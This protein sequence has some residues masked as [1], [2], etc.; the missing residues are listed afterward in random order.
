MK[1]AVYAVKGMSCA[2]C[3]VRIEKVVGRLDGVDNASVNLAAEKLALS[4]N[5]QRLNEATLTETVKNIG[6]ELVTEKPAAIETGGLRRESFGIAGMTCA[7]CSTRIEKALHAL[8]G[9]TEASVN[10]AAERAQVVFRPETVRLFEIKAAVTK[11]GYT[12]LEE[13]AASGDEHQQRKDREIRSLK[14]SFLISL[15]FTIPLFYLAM[16]PMLSFVRLPF[17]PFLYPMAQPLAY[18]LT[19]FALT[20]PA[21]IAGRRFYT[22]GFKALVQL[23][24]NMDT[25]IAVGTSAAL[26]YSLYSTLRIILGDARGVEQLY[27]ESAGVIIT[28][29]LLGKTLEA[30]SKGRAGQAIKKLMRLA[31]ATT[32][33]VRDGAEVTVPVRDLEPGDL[34]RVH[35]GERVP[36][37]GAVTEGYSAVDESML[38]GEPI[39]V[40]KMT[41]SP[42]YGGSLNKN[43]TILFRAEK[44]GRETALARII[45]LVEDAQGKKAPIARLA[46]VVSGWFVPLVIGVAGLSLVLWLLAGREFVFAFT[47]FTAVLVIACPCALGLA[48]PAA[49]MTGTGRGAELGILFKSGPALETA[50]RVTTVVLDKTGTLTVGRPRVTAVDAAPGWTEDDV[51]FLAASAERHS[52]HPLAEA[53]LAEAAR[54]GLTPEEPNEFTAVPG[55]GLRARVGSRVLVLGNEKLMGT[56][57]VEYSVLHDE[58]GRLSS[59]GNTVLYLAAD[60]RIAGIVGCADTLKPGAAAAVAELNQLGLECIM[61]TGDSRMAAVAVAAQAGITA[62]EAEVLPADKAAVVQQF[63]AEGKKVIMAGDGINDAPALAQADVGV[64]VGSGTDVAIEAADIVLTRNELSDIPAAVRLARKTMRVIKQNLF[65]AFCYNV[66]GIPVAA[67]LLTLFGGPQLNPMFAAAAMSM[68]SV[69]VVTNALRLKRFKR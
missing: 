37:D 58:A 11:L 42:V 25:L 16:A 9:V 31:P 3:A 50:S 59:T 30:R 14:R 54:R 21:V 22:R 55:H 45:Q 51:I 68:S 35:P 48:T 23:S 29:I 69:S 2:A 65:W 62:V 67:G 56:E 43:G 49:I 8:P 53:V 7:A 46:D 66:I 63:Q 32:S 64:A 6:Y 1:K 33:L 41:G 44:V 38:T 17:P 60:S 26:L 10:L 24:P 36:V 57:R 34:V 20:L 15:I 39:P 4:F 28:L 47:A 12:P 61:L 19:L 40:E 13:T 18:A 5:D 52:E 27:F